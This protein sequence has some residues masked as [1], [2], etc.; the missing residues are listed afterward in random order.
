LRSKQSTLLLI[1]KE[2]SISEYTATGACFRVTW[3]DVVLASLTVI[4]HLIWD[5]MCNWGSLCTAYFIGFWCQWLGGL[6]VHFTSLCTFTSAV[7]TLKRKSWDIFCLGNFTG[8][9]H[10]GSLAIRERKKTETIKNNAC[11]VGSGTL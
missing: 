4:Q 9:P 6:S 3:L 11:W 8:F 1:V 7:F 10:S 2:E 5:M